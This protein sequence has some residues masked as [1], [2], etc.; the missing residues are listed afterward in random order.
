MH[1][2]TVLA[3]AGAAALPLGG[4]IGSAD[5]GAAVSVEFLPQRFIAGALRPEAA[6]QREVEPGDVRE[7]A[8]LP[9]PLRSAIEEAVDGGFERQTVSADLLRAIDRLRG[10]SMTDRVERPYVRVD[11]RV[12]VFEPKVPEVLVEP[13]PAATPANESAVFDAR[14]FHERADEFDPAVADLVGALKYNG[15][16]APRVP[17]SRSYVPDAVENFLDRYD[18][19]EDAEGVFRIDVTW[20]HTEPPYRIEV[21]EFTD[22]DRYNRRIVDAAD[23][24][25]EVRAFCESVV[26]A[27][28]RRPSPPFLP[29][30]V[31]DGFFETLQPTGTIRKDP[32]VRLDGT[33]YYVGVTRAEYE[34]VPVDVAV[35]PR[36]P[37]DGDRPGFTVR[38]SVTDGG[39]ATDVVP[40]EPVDLFGHAGIPG[41]LWI[42]HDGEFHILNSEDYRVDLE[43]E[44]VL[45]TAAVATMALQIGDREVE[46]YAAEERTESTSWSL[47]LD[48]DR[49]REATVTEAV[50]VGEN[51][52]ATYAVPDAVPSGTYR[53]PGF[54]GARW[55]ADPPPLE[56]AVYPFEIE[57][58]LDR[59]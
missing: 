32:F 19:L 39:A 59:A 26:A 33:V 9:E 53:L 57:L 51:R 22:E 13:G 4:C 24:T 42:E 45:G 8:E 28:N 30:S 3:A 18:Y 27:S 46:L 54:F 25:P 52:T 48:V 34:R 50:P 47:D 2:R 40:G 14:D 21:R 37:G 16:N 58:E 41:L 35:E 56:S 38:L 31:P 6:N 29:E 49:I 44:S 15:P 23:L 20:R 43:R 55:P 5:D 17:H 12:Y 1:R 10:R 36:S 7:L 11:G